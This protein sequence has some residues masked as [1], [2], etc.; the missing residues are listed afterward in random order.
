MGKR[1]DQQKKHSDIRLVAG[2]QK[3]VLMNMDRYGRQVVGHPEALFERKIEPTI[4]SINQTLKSVIQNKEQTI[5]TYN[6]R[7]EIT[8]THDLDE[9]RKSV[10]TL[11]DIISLLSAQSRLPELDCKDFI[12][13]FRI[14]KLFIE[15]SEIKAIWRNAISTHYILLAKVFESLVQDRQLKDLG[16]VEFIDQD[17]SKQASLVNLKRAHKVLKQYFE[18]KK[19]GTI[20]NPFF[21]NKTEEETLLW[22][23]ANTGLW[24][25]HFEDTHDP[26]LYSILSGFDPAISDNRSYQKVLYLTSKT[27]YQIQSA[28]NTSLYFLLKYLQ[29]G[30]LEEGEPKTKLPKD[31][32]ERLDLIK[33]IKNK[34]NEIPS[35]EISE[36]YPPQMSKL[37]IDKKLTDEDIEL[38]TRFIFSEGESTIPIPDFIKHKKR[39]LYLQSVSGY[40]ELFEGIAGL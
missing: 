12:K 5:A 16:I 11:K 1:L 35:I 28:N 6:G 20:N 8:E 21:T 27:K 13:N 37:G 31:F 14:D 32:D 29:A 39:I 40:L 3:Q 22:M 2:P 25:E 24:H 26:V 15:S 23:Q 36:D 33:K 9:M 30:Y 19:E 38:L 18:H 7:I 10:K 4:T 17:G 34:L